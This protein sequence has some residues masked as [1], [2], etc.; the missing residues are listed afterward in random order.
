MIKQTFVTN[1]DQNELV[2]SYVKQF[3][4]IVSL[5]SKAIPTRERAPWLFSAE[6]HSYKRG[7][8]WPNVGQ[9]VRVRMNKTPKSVDYK[10][11]L[12]TENI[13]Q[14]FCR[15]LTYLGMCDSC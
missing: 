11:L 7:S 10:N 4:F 6:K 12:T 5:N 3:V 2:A 9:H 15:Q 1:S 8:D 14:I 13:E